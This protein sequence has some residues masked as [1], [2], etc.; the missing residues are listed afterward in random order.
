MGIANI[1]KL[2][3]LDFTKQKA[4]AYLICERPYPVSID[5]EDMQA[6]LCLQE[7]SNS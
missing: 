5:Y 6:L 3:P 1:E 2:R 4:F 7:N